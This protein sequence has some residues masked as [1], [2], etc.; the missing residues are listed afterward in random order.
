M[1]RH[2]AVQIQQLGREIEKEKDTGN[3]DIV[4]W[5]LV[6]VTN[7]KDSRVYSGGCV[8]PKCSNEMAELARRH[9]DAVAAKK[10][11][12]TALNSSTQKLH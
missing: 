2:I 4:T 11:S 5:A 8:C 1:S 3:S 6:M 10:T 12:K 7:G 9:A